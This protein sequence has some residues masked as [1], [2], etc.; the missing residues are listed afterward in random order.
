MAQPR[1]ILLAEDDPH[2]VELTL[3]ALKLHGLDRNVQVVE[4]GEEALEFMQRRG[5]YAD[6]IPG[7]PA[8][9]LLDLKMPKVD[10]LEVLREVKSHSETSS[11][12]VVVM[13]SSTERS[14]VEKSYKLG[15][16]AFVVKPIGVSD[17]VK[18]LGS[19]ACFWSQLNEPPPQET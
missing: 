9:I 3:A 19:I 17:F 6:R 10:G 12:P 5:R 2:G 4:D 18:T 8:V 16:N 1:T 13:T 7:N 15:T 11:T 14:D